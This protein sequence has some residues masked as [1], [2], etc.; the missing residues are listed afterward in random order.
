MPI[1]DAGAVRNQVDSVQKQLG[2]FAVQEGQIR[3]SITMAIQNAW[4]SVALAKEMLDLASLSAQT[5]ELQYQLTVAERD[6]GTASNQ[7]VFTASV[8]QATAETALATARNTLQLAELQL[9]NAM[10]Y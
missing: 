7:D 1:L 3:K 6:Q 8:N 10:G 9:Q 4:Q 5:F 2:V